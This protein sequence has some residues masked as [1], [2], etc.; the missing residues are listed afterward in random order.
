MFPKILA[1]TLL[2]SLRAMAAEAQLPTLRTE[3]KS[4]GSIFFVKNTSSVPLTAFLIEL[5]GYP[6]SSYALWQDD[7]DGE[8]LAPGKERK[9][10]VQNMTVG[11]VPDYV[12]VQA[13]IYADGST[14]GLPDR[15]EKLLTRRRALV[16]AV[17]NLLHRLELAQQAKIE[18]SNLAATLRQAAEFMVV[19]PG[20]DKMSNYA[21]SQTVSRALFLETA[22]FVD[23]HMMDETKARLLAKEKAFKG[24]KPAI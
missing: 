19:P 4:G 13:A 1:A 2:F 11:A 7:V 14:A 3:P 15:I 21:L 5:V 9:I 22:D 8:P 10:E 20:T 12:K 23:V 6:G 17:Q 24:S 18:R 16:E